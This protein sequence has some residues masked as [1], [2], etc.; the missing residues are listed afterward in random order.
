MTHIRPVN[1][2]T[3]EQSDW[4]ALDN[5]F[6][7]T[8]G[9]AFKAEPVATIGSYLYCHQY[10]YISPRT[11]FVL[12]SEAGEAGEVVGYILGTPSTAEYARQYRQLL[13]DMLSKLAKI[14]V[15]PPPDYAAEGREAPTFDEDAAAH[16]LYE[17]C[18]KTEESLNSEMPELWEKWPAHFHIDILPSHQRQGWGRKMIETMLTALRAEGAQGVH[19]GMEAHNSGAEKFYSAM[20]FER[21]PWPLDGG[22]SGENGKQDRTLYLVK[23]LGE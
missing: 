2:S 14:G 17:A 18:H 23:T 13:P 8:S 21:Y 1:L 6:R 15:Q 3:K 7:T 5:I 16:L 22:V 12:E 9:P 11:C 4:A 20:G 10:P 19:L